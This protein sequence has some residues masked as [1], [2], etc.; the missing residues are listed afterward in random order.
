MQVVVD[1]D[2]RINELDARGVAVD[3]D[4]TPDVFSLVFDP[5]GKRSFFFTI[6]GE[7]DEGTSTRGREVEGQDGVRSRESLR[8]SLCPRSRRLHVRHVGTHI[9]GKTGG[10]SVRTGV[11][12]GEAESQSTRPVAA[13]LRELDEDPLLLFDRTVRED[14]G[15]AVGVDSCSRRSVGVEAD[16]FPVNRVEEDGRQVVCCILVLREATVMSGSTGCNTGK[17]SIRQVN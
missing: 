2:A 13:D 15:F 16:V 3:V 17:A 7:V 11:R 10:S 9:F 12:G 14:D 1:G 4:E 5:N 8:Q 6:D